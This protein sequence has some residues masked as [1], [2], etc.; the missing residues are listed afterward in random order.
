MT[1]MAESA[2]LDTVKT[3][4]QSWPE[5]A[6]AAIVA[7]AE[8]YAS[9]GELLKGIKSLR[10]KIA[11]T[12]DPHVKR[13]HEAHKALVK[14]KADAEAPLAEAERI[15]KAALI[16]F[17]QEQERLRVAEQRRLDE[18]ARAE[19][20]TR[21]LNLAAAM[22]KEGNTFGDAA[23]VAEAEELISAPVMVAA[24]AVA[25]TTPKVSG[26]AM[27]TTYRAQVTDLLALVKH[28]AANPQ[29][30]PLLQV[31]QTA[32]NGQ[33]RS[34]KTSLRLPGVQVLAD[35]TVRAGR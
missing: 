2:E 8:Q 4:A 22:E 10:A 1:P 9:A 7:T 34:L 25:R 30:L 29:L 15:L 28:V 33:A 32:L 18:I 5:R 12:F 20:E 23:M 14:E 31:N 35:Q 26:I 19:E 27:A 11:E 17:D 3:E 21:R 13:A 6:R 16:A 24:P